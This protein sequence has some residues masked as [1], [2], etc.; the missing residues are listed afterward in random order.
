MSISIQREFQRRHDLRHVGDDSTLGIGEL[1]EEVT[2]DLLVDRELKHLGV[3]HNELQLF[4]ALAV[5]E[6]GDEGI[7]PDALPLTCSPCDE[8]VGHLR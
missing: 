3:D 8:Q 6:R 5:E 4:G 2:L 1:G 7:Q